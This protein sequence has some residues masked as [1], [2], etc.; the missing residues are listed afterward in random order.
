MG[1]IKK[2]TKNKTLSYL[3]FN[4]EDLDQGEEVQ[5]VGLDIKPTLL[6]FGVKLWP[7]VTELSTSFQTQFIKVLSQNFVTASCS[8]AMYTN[9]C[10]RERHKDF[11]EK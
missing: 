9:G 4:L 6:L 3:G 7:A 5:F 10:H 8:I 2:K 1:T 11:M